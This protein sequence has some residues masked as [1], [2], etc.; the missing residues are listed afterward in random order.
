MKHIRFSTLLPQ[1]QSYKYDTVYYCPITNPTDT[2][3]S[4]FLP[5]QVLL[6]WFNPPIHQY[7]SYRYDTVHYCLSTS[8]IDT[9]SL[10]LPSIS[11]IDTTQF[12]SA[13]V[14]VLP[15]WYHISGPVPELLIDA[16]HDY[17]NTSPTDTLQSTTAPVPVLLISYNLLLPSTSLIDR[18]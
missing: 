10:L 12:T 11:H 13:P 17:P 6:I 3:Q 15:I 18:T 7:R 2:T 8:P 5:V 9:I 16:V 1:Y 14:P 4:T